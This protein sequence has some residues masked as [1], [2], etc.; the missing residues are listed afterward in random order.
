MKPIDLSTMAKAYLGTA[1]WSSTNN[2]DPNGGFPLDND[3]DLYDLT[4]ES[5]KRAN[6][7]C[8]DF[9]EMC[10]EKGI[11]LDDFDDE[12]LGHDFW[13]TRNGHGAGFWDGDYPR[14]IGQALS[15]IAHSFGSCDLYLTV[16]DEEGKHV[17]YG[18]DDDTCLSEDEILEAYHSGRFDVEIH[19]A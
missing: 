17:A 5:L 19:M 3:F 8:E 7:D 10:E 11:S 15:K 9:L 16:T 14:E 6:Q 13:L 12:Q 1:L 4:D 18:S 2:L